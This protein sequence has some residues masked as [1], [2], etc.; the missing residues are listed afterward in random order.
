SAKNIETYYRQKSTSQPITMSI[1]GAIVGNKLDVP[2]AISGISAVFS[3]VR[4]VGDH[5]EYFDYDIDKNRGFQWLENNNLA[6][7][8]SLEIF[9]NNAKMW[10]DMRW[11]RGRDFVPFLCLT[12]QEF[13]IF[14][15]MPTDHN[16]PIT[17]RRKT[18]RGLNNRTKIFLWGRGI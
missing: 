9:K 7:A 2:A 6:S 1:R 16:L 12:P 18:L 14:V 11:G 5:L 13:S 17:F 15:S 8:Y 3:S 4:F 10:A